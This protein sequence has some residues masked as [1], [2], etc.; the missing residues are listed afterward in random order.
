MADFPRTIVP[1]EVSPFRVPTGLVSRG[2][3]G[4]DQLRSIVAMGREWDELYPPMRA[5]T[6]AVDAFL[7][8]LEYAWN[9]QIVFQVRHLPSPGSGRS[10]HGAGGGT[11]RVLGGS[12]TGSTINTDGWTAS[13]TNVVRA[14][15]VIRIAGVSP[16]L[17]VVADASSNASGQATLTINP[18]LPVGSSPLD[19]ALITRT[20]A[21][22]NAY[23]SA[24]PNLPRV[25]P[26]QWMGGITLSFREAL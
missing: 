4:K 1:R 22:L 26:G 13:V 5:G 6:Q 10:P 15:D 7:A 9:Q 23:L 8:Y 17:R 18:A 24:Q 16:L 3:T 20:N 19:N 11:P 12:Q 25:A 2:S 14:G 21:H